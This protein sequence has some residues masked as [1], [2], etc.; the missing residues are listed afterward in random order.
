[1]GYYIFHEYDSSTKIKAVFTEKKEQVYFLQ[2]G[3]YSDLE[4]AKESAK[5]FTNYI[6][7]LEDGKYHVYIGMTKS[8]KNVEKLKGFFKEKGYI[9]YVKEMIIT[10]DSFIERLLQYDALLEKTEEEEV[11]LKIIEKILNEYKE[12]VIDGDNN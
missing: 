12:V 8:T 4:S 3:V 10:N 9:I 11:I 5:N 7:T 1:M 2:L 6:Y